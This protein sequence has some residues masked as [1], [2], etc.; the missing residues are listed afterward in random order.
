MK[1]MYFCNFI[2]T[3]GGLARIVIEK[4]NYLSKK[5]EVTILTFDHPN[6][7]TYYEL[8]SK[9]IHIDYS[10]YSGTNNIWLSKQKFNR[11][12]ADVKPD[13]I[14]ALTGKDSLV[15]PFFNSS[16]PKLKEMHFTHGY[17]KIHHKNSGLLKRFLVSIISQ[18][19]LWV[20]SKYDMIIP[21]T[22]EDEVKWNL[23]NTKVIY[24]FK[25]IESE[26]KALLVSK[27]VIAVGRLN[28][29]KGFDLLLDAWKQVCRSD[30][31]WKLEIYG[32]GP[33]KNEL[34]ELSKSLNITDRVSF[35]GNVKSIKRRYLQSSI[36][37]MSSR[38]EGL[39]LSLIEAMECGLSIVSFSCPSGPTEIIN[40]DKDGFLVEN[41]NSLKLANKLLELMNNPEKR[42]I[43]GENAIINAKQFNK[44]PIMQEWE[45]LFTHI[46]QSN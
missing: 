35:K 37:V 29:E 38:H 12:L 18:L 43:L 7:K 3:P 22:Y 10:D 11:I 41:G 24:N 26:E 36:F 33:L 23:K 14:I 21:L 4:A 13:I 5:H 16:I 31:K 44:E 45:N 39:P 2:A 34:L 9:I 6:K 30:D 32:D 42:K 15:L 19:E 1:I 20:F 8:S 28:H 40:N 25:T 17:R 27:T 46:I